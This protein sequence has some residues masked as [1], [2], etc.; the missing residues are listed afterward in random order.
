MNK[1]I[2][3]DI[4][5]WRDQRQQEEAKLTRIHSLAT[6]ARREIERLRA[7]RPQI[8]ARYD[9]MSAERTLRIDLPPVSMCFKVDS[10]LDGMDR[11]ALTREAKRHLIEDLC[12]WM[13]RNWL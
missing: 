10:R 6:E 8:Y 11:G 1:F 3:A 4:A 5:R 9:R 7:N 2:K 13:K 12:E